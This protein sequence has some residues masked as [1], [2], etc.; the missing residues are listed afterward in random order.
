MTTLDPVTTQAESSPLQ[1]LQ[2]LVHAQAAAAR[3]WRAKLPTLRA[4]T[5][6][7]LFLLEELAR[8]PPTSPIPDRAHADVVLS[9]PTREWAEDVAS[10]LRHALPSEAR[11]DLGAPGDTRRDGQPLTVFTVRCQVSLPGMRGA[12]ATKQVRAALANMEDLETDYSKPLDLIV[13]SPSG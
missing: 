10:R 13:V 9:A 1:R 6:A 12:Q 8:T 11:I 2:S 4:Q 7:T 3:E 5:S